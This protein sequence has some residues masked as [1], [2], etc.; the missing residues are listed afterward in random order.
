M[1]ST[2]SAPATRPRPGARGPPQGGEED[3]AVRGPGE[4]EQV[5]PRGTG[6]DDQEDEDPPDPG[7]GETRTPSGP[8]LTTGR[9]AGETGEGQEDRGRPGRRRAPPRQ[10]A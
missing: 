6:P 3:K 7:G 2:R 9:P 5:V 10:G 4:G 8:A 1:P